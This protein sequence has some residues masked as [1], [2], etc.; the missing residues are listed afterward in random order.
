MLIL[1]ALA[2]AKVKHVHFTPTAG[3]GCVVAGAGFDVPLS[4]DQAGIA[5][6]IAGVARHQS[7]PVRAVTIAYATALQESHLLNLS[8]G[9]RDSV[10]V[11][12]QRPS[13]GWGTRQQLLDPVYATTRFFAALATVSGYQHLLIYQ[14]AQAVQH[15][16]DGHAYSQYAPQG[17]VMAG[18]FTGQ[19]PHDVW[20]W[21]GAGDASRGRLAAADR[22][23]TR[24]FGQLSIVHVK[25]PMMRVRVHDASVGWAVATWLVTHAGD[26]GITH[27]IYQGYQWTA[28]RGRKGWT[29]SPTSGHRAAAR[30][31]VAFG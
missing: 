19:R 24:A 10:G 14:A 22:Q 6:T 17:A 31:I 20:C 12:Q 11:F 18:G 13:Q 8:Y 4:S 5:A 26:F 27:V 2:L 3:T 7:M 16:A 1:A 28:T 29:T 9:D 21:Y 30:G 15:S 25:D 23:L